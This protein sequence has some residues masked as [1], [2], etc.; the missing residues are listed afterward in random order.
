[1]RAGTRVDTSGN[2]GDGGTVEARKP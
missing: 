2:S 1:M